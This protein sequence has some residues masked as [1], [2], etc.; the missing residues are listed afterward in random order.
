MHCLEVEYEED[1]QS[2]SQSQHVEKSV[3]FNEELDYKERG[4]GSQINASLN[5]SHLEISQEEGFCLLDSIGENNDISSKAN[6]EG[7]FLN[8]EILNEIVDISFEN[9]HES[10]FQISFENQFDSIL[11]D[12]HFGQLSYGKERREYVESM[13]RVVMFS[14]IRWKNTWRGW[15]MVMTGYISTVKINLFVI[16]FFHYVS[17]H[18]F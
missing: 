14:M 5:I 17:H 11:E 3:V 1:E 15:V 16:T 8:S 2:C 4:K 13:L 10:S 18:C 6:K 12:L 9:N 7:E